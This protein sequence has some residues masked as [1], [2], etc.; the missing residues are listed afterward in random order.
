M[1]FDYGKKTQVSNP[2][3]QDWG[4]DNKMKDITNRKD[5]ELLIDSFYKKV[6]KDELIGDFFTKV[7]ALDWN[8]HIPIMY[9]FWESI[10]FGKAKY[11]GNPMIKHIDLSNKKS[12]TDKHFERWL[13]LW[14]NTV[15][16]NFYGEKAKEA[17]QQAKN[18][19]GLMK[20]KI[21]QYSKK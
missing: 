14:E 6:V 4:K 12:L 11:K 8:V 3:G 7:V 18:I 19:S 9:D 1:S 5:V 21:A 20:L 15:N 16:E 13:F 10:L 2:K 17:V